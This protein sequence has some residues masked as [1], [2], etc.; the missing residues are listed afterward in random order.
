MQ[1]F[2]LLNSIHAATINAAYAMELKDEVGSIMIGKKANLIS[3]KPISSLAYLPYAFGNNL[4]D[5]MMID[6]EFI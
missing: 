1:Q 5:K 4:I 3:T 6:G 2:V